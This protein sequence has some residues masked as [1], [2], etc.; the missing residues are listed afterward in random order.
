M[1]N[2]NEFNKALGYILRRHKHKMLDL[3]RYSNNRSLDQGQTPIHE[4]GIK[5]GNGDIG[6][7]IF[8]NESFARVY[9]HIGSISDYIEINYYD[10]DDFISNNEKLIKELIKDVEAKFLAS[11]PNY[12]W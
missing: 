8:K 11:N 6:I 12:L 1:F 5:W 4:Y 7:R 2:K 3:Q 10:G 9:C